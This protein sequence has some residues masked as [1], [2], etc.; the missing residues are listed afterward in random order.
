MPITTDVVGS[1]LDQGEVYNIMWSKVCQWPKTGRWFS[2][3]PPVSSTNKTNRHDINEILLKVALNTIKQAK[4]YTLY[5]DI[6]FV[7]QQR[8]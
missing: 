1:Y 2:P 6:I 8:K 3:G 4:H 7:Q 5:I